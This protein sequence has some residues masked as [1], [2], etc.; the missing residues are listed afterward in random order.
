VA[1]RIGGAGGGSDP[2]NGKSS[3]GGTVLAVTVAVAVSVGGI[4]ATGTATLS[5]GASSGSSSTSG[6]RTTSN[7]RTE[8]RGSSQDA[9]TVQARLARQGFRVNLNG[10][11]ADTDCV[12][13]SYGQVQNFFRQHPCVAL[14]RAWLDVQDSHGDVVLVAVSWVRMADEASASALQS[15]SMPPVP[16]M[17]PNCLVRKGNI[18]QSGTPVNFILPLSASLGLCL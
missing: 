18:D 5:S 2:G 7:A 9:Q 17:L 15:W 14:F 1:R 6:T 12:S 8:S 10:L 11:R 3:G 16:E 13:H 4:T